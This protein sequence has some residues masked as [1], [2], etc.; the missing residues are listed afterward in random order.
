[1]K[2]KDALICENCQEILSEIILKVINED[3]CPKCGC[4]DILPLKE[5]LR[6][7]LKE[8]IKQ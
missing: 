5:Y 4:T 6:E 8:T 7:K 1:M 2:L 3:R